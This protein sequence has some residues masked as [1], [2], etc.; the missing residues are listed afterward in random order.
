VERR[1]NSGTT[2]KLPSLY[3]VNPGERATDAGIVDPRLSRAQ[4][5]ARLLFRRH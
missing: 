2:N 5:R 4:K 1:D 3:R